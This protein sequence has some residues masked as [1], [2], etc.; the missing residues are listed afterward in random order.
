MPTPP[1]MPRRRILACW[2]GAAAALVLPTCNWARSD[3][4][5]L[6]LASDAPADVDPAGHLVSEKFDGVR[7]FWDGRQLR[8]RGGAPV[9]A[10]AWFSA[11]LPP[12]RPSH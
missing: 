7:V 4:P 2:A 10:P 1:P 6:L 11:G 8:L 12:G 9:A 3:M 5:A